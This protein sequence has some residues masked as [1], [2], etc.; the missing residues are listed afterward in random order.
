MQTTIDAVFDGTVLRLDH[1]LILAPNTRVRLTIELLE[2][3]PSQPKSFLKTA[4]SLR[5]E[6][7]SDL[8]TNIDAYLYGDTDDATP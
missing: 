8:A 3:I 4:R 2:P 6:A 5:I 1:P 7:P